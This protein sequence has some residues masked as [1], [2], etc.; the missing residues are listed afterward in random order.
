MRKCYDVVHALAARLIH[1]S[2]HGGVQFRA[3]AALAERIEKVALLV[4]KVGG[5]GFGKRLRRGYAD[6]GDAI[7]AASSTT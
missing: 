3:F 2:L 6:K 1:G 7:A 4:L 5:R